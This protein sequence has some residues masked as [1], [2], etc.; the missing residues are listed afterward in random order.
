[1]NIDILTLFPR[2]VEVP[3]NES[4]IGKAVEADKLNI[5]VTDFRKFSTNKH[6]NVD[7]YPYG[8][9][10]GMLLTPQPI[11]DAMEHVSQK[12]NGKMGRVILVDPA[13]KRF[14]QK[15]AEEFSK[16]EQLTFICGHYEGY[17]ERI[18]TLVTDEVSL[19]DFVITGGELAALTIIDATVRLIPEILGNKESAPGDS[20]S[21]GLLEYPQYTRP[22]NFRGMEVPSILL[23]GDHGKVDLWRRQQSLKKTSERRPDLIHKAKLSVADLDY[24]ADLKEKK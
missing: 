20:Y 5:D 12:N 7:D 8:G 1:M 18:K 9:G 10:A 14:N 24:L 23:S 6:G 17:D 22:A 15:M 13:G 19:G 4:I 2:M 3:L 16:E 11:F 21:S